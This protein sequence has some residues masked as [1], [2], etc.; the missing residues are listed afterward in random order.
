MVDVIHWCLDLGVQY[1]SV[2]AF[3]IDNFQRSHDEVAALMHLAESKYKE[4]AQ[5]Q[6]LGVLGCHG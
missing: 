5:V 1:I 4:L 2:Y 6:I 3:S